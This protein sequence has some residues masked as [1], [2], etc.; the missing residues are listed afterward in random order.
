M[1]GW[2]WIGLIFAAAS[3]SCI[4]TTPEGRARDALGGEAPG[5]PRGPEHRPG[6]PCLVCHSPEGD[7]EEPT[8]LVAGTVYRPDGVTPAMGASVTIR[9]AMDREVTATTNRVGN[10]MI[11]VD[12]DLSAPRARADGMLELPWSL[13]FPLFVDPVSD[14]SDMRRMRSPIGREGSCAHCHLQEVNEISAGRV[15]VGATP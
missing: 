9:D 3:A 2:Y 5:V 11:V 13:T 6:Q 1:K 15:V 8:F 12:E 10:F 7:G 14:G 4:G